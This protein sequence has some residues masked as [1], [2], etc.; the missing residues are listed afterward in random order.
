MWDVVSSVVEKITTEVASKIKELNGGNTVSA[1]FVVGGGGKV[2]GFTEN[3]AKEL[4][5]PEERVAL[6]GEEVLGEVTFQQPDIKKD[7]L[8]VTPIGICL[9]YYEQRN[10]FIMVRFNG[11]RLKLYDNNRLT[12][13][14][15]ALQ[16]GFPNDQ[17]FPKRGV[18]I[19]FTV[20]GASRIARGEAGEAAIV[21]MNGQHANI[22]TPLEPNSEITIEPSTAGD[23]AVYTIGQLEEYRSS[24]I[25]FIVNGHEVTC[26]KFVQ[27][28]GSLEPETYHIK[29]GDAIEMRNFYTVE[30]VAEFM[31]VALEPDEDIYVN[32]APATFDTLVYENFSINWKD[33]PYGVARRDDNIYT[34]TE[35]ND[36][37]EDEAEAV[38]NEEISDE[39]TESKA[40]GSDETSESK[41]TGSDGKSESKE[42]GSD[43]KSESKETESDGISENMT[44]ESD[45][46]AE[47]EST[48]EN[49]TAEDT[50][51]TEETSNMYTPSSFTK[52]DGK[53]MVVTVNGEPVELIGKEA[54]IFVDIFNRIT[55]DLNAG[56][57]RAIATIINGRDAQFTE[58][59][60]DGDKIELYWKEN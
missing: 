23:D 30:Q 45:E 2:H 47:N 7:P 39:T 58:E 28:N 36:G 24:T 19:N 43:G 26:P 27:V 41:E 46:T 29:E 55:F 13:V 11:E 32:N 57:G 1:C 16:A 56:K 49:K 50:T 12:I 21:T 14:D 51:K 34:V 15:A 60:H 44:A 5:L 40:A 6:R 48:S 42:T 22:N 53:S 18:P 38:E 8:L 17:L 25:K 9:N 35:E 52:Q 54:Y 31:D 20:N 4:D 3:L 59:L 33:D 37:S 10:N